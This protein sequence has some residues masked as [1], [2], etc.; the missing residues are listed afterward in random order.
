[1]TKSVTVLIPNDVDELKQNGYQLCF[2][3]KVNNTFSVVWQSYGPP[4]GGI[5][6]QG[7]FYATNI[8]TW[9]PLYQIFGTN[10]FQTG[11]TVSAIT[12]QQNITLGQQATLD[13]YGTFGQAVS[14]GPTTGITLVNNYGMIHP[15]LNS[16]STGPDGVQ[17]T[18]AVYVAQDEIETGSDILTPIDVVQ[19]WFAQNIVTS[20][21]ISQAVS[22]ATTVDLTTTDS[23]TVKYDA[24][25]WSVPAATSAMV[26]DP[27]LYLTILV[28][29]VAAI[30]AAALAQKI[31]TYLTGVYQSFSVKVDGTK[32]QFKISY[33]EQKNLSALERQYV[34]ALWGDG[35]G[36]ADQLTAFALQ[37]LAALNASFTEFDATV[38]Q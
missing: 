7:D 5:T 20:T 36:T 11:V 24:G 26:S 21:M 15:A 23:A 31:G 22:N 32:G 3:K 19:I 12:N 9:V 1:M 28:K 17:R 25:A 16:I 30:T 34:E 8:F 33:S 14:G 29:G 6:P 18:T 2:A 37:S 27:K 13:Q 35:V 4:S 38:A 10:S